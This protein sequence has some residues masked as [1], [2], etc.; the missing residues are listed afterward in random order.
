[1]SAELNF[2]LKEESLSGGESVSF[3]L[4][5]VQLLNWVWL[6]ATPWTA[7]CQAS[8]SFTISWSLLQL[9]FIEYNHLTISSSLSP[10]SSC[11]QSFPTS[12][13]FPMYG[14]YASGGPASR[15]IC[16]PWLMVPFFHF[17]RQYHWVWLVF[18]VTAPS[19]YYW[20]RLSAFK[21]YHDFIGPTM[22]IQDCCYLV[23]K[24]C[25]TPCTPWP[26]TQEAPLSMGFPRQEYWNGLHFLRQVIFPTKGSNLGHLHWQ[27]DSGPPGRPRIIQDNLLIS[28]PPN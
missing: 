22:I 7:A 17:Q 14:L 21:D 3:Q 2:L 26:I 15:G 8:L 11:P 5:I 25:P 12:R 28:R 13:S 23:T 1:M 18:H 20:K 16:V 4:Q 6:F 10:F 19:K 24:L 9:L 27:A